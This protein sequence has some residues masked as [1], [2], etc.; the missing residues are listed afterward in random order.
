G[1]I[2]PQQRYF[3][4]MN[5]QIPGLVHL[6]EATSVENNVKHIIEALP[7]FTQ[8]PESPDPLT[9]FDFLI[10]WLGRNKP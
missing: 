8:L 1:I 2:E 9:L 3:Q 5:T 7:S 6:I 4:A 10:K